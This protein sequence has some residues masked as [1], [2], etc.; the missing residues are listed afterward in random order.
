MSIG[1]NALE[2]FLQSGGA[3][4]NND[5]VFDEQVDAEAFLEDHTVVFEADDFL[6]FDAEA[7]AFQFPGE[8]S[9]I[10]LIPS[11]ALG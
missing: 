6:A 11:F 7:A 2:A 10:F 1:D 4:F 8:D 3:E 5:L 9:L